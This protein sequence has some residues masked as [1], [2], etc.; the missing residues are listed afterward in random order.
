MIVG[1][2]ATRELVEIVA[3][4]DACVHRLQQIRSRPNALLAA[5]DVLVI[6]AV[7]NQNGS[8]DKRIVECLP[9]PP[10][11][12]T[13]NG[14]QDQRQQQQQNDNVQYD[15]NGLVEIFSSKSSPKKEILLKSF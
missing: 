6:Q 1:P 12:L 3:R 10:F 4:V 13:V 2:I 5:A 7:C 8:C 9:S 11:E 14:H 15:E